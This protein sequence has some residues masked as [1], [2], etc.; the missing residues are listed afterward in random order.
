[1]EPVNPGTVGCNYRNS[2]E[3]GTPQERY[4][5]VDS[6]KRD[7]GAWPNANAY[8]LHLVNPVRSIIKVD[9]VFAVANLVAGSNV[10]GL[11]DIEEFRSQ[12]GVSD[13]RSNVA[14]STRTGPMV[15]N[16]FG[17]LPINGSTEVVWQEGGNYKLSVEF[18]QPIESIDRLNIRWTDKY[19]NLL[20][21]GPQGN[22]FLLRVYTTRL[23]A[24]ESPEEV[25][26]ELPQKKWPMDIIAVLALVLFILVMSLR[27]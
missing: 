16:T 13:L 24:P 25:T 1:M 7:T 20:N 12:F 3:P 27:T 10:Y 19:G 11:L 23:P 5:L 2:Q 6:S 14:M 15:L 17:V 21:F 4:L 18:Q 22:Q 8:V 9:L 26:A